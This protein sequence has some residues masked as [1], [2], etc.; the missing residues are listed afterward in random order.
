M[1][2]PA[3]PP[4]VVPPG[5]PKSWPSASAAEVIDGAIRPAG[6][7]GVD[8]DDDPVHRILDDA[9]PWAT[10]R[11]IFTEQLFGLGPMPGQGWKLHVSAGVGSAAVVLDNVMP[12]LLSEGVAFKVVGTTRALLALNSGGWGACQV[13]KFVTVYPS[14]DDQAVRLALALDRAT[15][16]LTGSRVPS[17]RPLRPGSLVHYRY[18][19]FTGG[20]E[21]YNMVDPAGRLARDWRL[22]FYRAPDPAITDPF[23][24]RG[25]YVPPPARP[26][27]LAGRYL[28]C[29]ALPVVQGRRV[30]GPRS[31]HE[32][33]A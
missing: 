8:A 19:A 4:L 1:T 27:P 32:A 11:G 33:G 24:E 15:A 5:S 17:D 25:A 31:R 20:T 29:Q 18:G 3:V 12:I 13:G 10:T 23:V 14:G 9:V 16:A 2:A 7:G 30:Q 26:A 28:V 6:V 22:Q 21:D